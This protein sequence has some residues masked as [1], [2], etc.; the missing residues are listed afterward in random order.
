MKKIE[1]KRNYSNRSNYTN[2]LNSVNLHKTVNLQD[3][4][5]N[6]L[7]NKLSN[8]FLNTNSKIIINIFR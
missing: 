4:K 7:I 2:D 5:V 1:A 3:K 6:N 8:L